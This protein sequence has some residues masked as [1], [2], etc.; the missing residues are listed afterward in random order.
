MAPRI[1]RAAQLKKSAAALLNSGYGK[2][3]MTMLN[4]AGA[5]Y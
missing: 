2:Y 5:P 3:L 4:E 1:D